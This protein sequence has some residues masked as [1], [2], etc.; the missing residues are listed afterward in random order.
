MAMC[1]YNM[2]KPR[3]FPKIQRRLK[4]FSNLLKNYALQRPVS[5]FPDSWS[6]LSKI[7]HLIIVLIPSWFIGP[8]YQFPV[9]KV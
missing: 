6:I 9:F 8:I 4:I 7:L 5:Y 2:M 1:K 3:N